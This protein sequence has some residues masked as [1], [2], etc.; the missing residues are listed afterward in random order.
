MINSDENSL[1][2][3]ARAPTHAYTQT[4]TH[5]RLHKNS[6]PRTWRGNYYSYSIKFKFQQEFYFPS[7]NWNTEFSVFGSSSFT[8]YTQN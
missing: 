5:S 4:H 3:R 8:Q 1:K 2:T 7:S 6:G